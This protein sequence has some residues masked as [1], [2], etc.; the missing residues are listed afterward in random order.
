MHS[1]IWI[2]IILCAIYVKSVTQFK[3]SL[4]SKMHRHGGC[5][6]ISP[7]SYDKRSENRFTV[8]TQQVLYF[9]S[10][11][12]S[13]LHCTAVPPHFHVVSAT[14]F[15]STSVPPHFHV[16]SDTA[17]TFILLRKELLCSLLT[18][19]RDLSDQP[20]CHK[21]FHLAI[22]FK[23]VAAKSLFSSGNIW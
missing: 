8:H 5:Y 10:S 7:A 19:F 22:V 14:T 4:M 23:F 16:V 11:K 13:W 9:D 21:C 12:N 17:N 6:V 3:P 2:Y 18:S 15:N 1:Y 20:S